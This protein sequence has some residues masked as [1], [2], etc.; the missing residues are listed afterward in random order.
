[1]TVQELKNLLE[2]AIEQGCG[3]MEVRF[4]YQ[5]NYPLQDTVAG[6]WAACLAETGF[7]SDEDVEELAVL[8]K[9]GH[10]YLVSGGQDR[11]M[12]YG[13]KRAFEECSEYL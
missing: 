2:Q 12:P 7:E 5:E 6:G 3:D 11:D 8:E 13:P 9:L 1:M 10:F 4:T